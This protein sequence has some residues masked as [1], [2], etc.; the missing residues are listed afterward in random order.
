VHLIESV[1]LNSRTHLIRLFLALAQIMVYQACAKCLS[2]LFQLEVFVEICFDQ[3][4]VDYL[5]SLNY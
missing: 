3:F 2:F 1:E 4:L 5:G